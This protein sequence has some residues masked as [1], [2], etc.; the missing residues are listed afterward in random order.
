MLERFLHFYG[1]F[2]HVDNSFSY[3]LPLY[4]TCDLVQTLC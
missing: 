3:M 4:R 2:S 1:P